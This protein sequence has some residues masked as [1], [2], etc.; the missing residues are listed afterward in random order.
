M[1]MDA[2]MDAYVSLLLPLFCT[3]TPSIDGWPKP[4]P[5]SAKVV[6]WDPPRQRVTQ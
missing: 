1:S 4:F 5:S 2:V 3:L 6:V